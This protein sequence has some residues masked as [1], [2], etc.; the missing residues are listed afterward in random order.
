MGRRGR[1]IAQ[2]GA[3]CSR[4]LQGLLALA[5]WT[6]LGLAP[7]PV[8]AQGAARLSLPTATGHRGAR[9]EVPLRLSALAGRPLAAG[10][11]QLRFDGGV[12]AFEEV[13]TTG[14]LSAGW[15]VEYHLQ[16]AGAS[17]TLR[18]GVA[19]LQSATADG[20]LLRLA[21]RIP[22]AAPF[23]G[24]S[25]L[26]L[27]DA[28]LEQDPAGALLAVQSSHGLVRVGAPPV[29]WVNEGL[30]L[31]EG[32]SAAITPAALRV[33]DVDNPPAELVY[34][35]VWAPAAGTLS[36]PQG[37]LGQGQTFTQADI[38]QG[39]LSY[40]HDGS[41]TTADAFAFSV[42]DG[43]G[44]PLAGFFAIQV[45]PVNDP[46][47]LLPIGVLQVDEGQVLEV[48]VS[49]SDPDG[50]P[51]LT[52]QGLPPF[53]AF[54]DRGDGTGLLRLAPG[55]NAAGVYTGIV[56][57]A[58]DGTNPALVDHQ[59][60]VLT[61]VNVDRPPVANAGADIRLPYATVSAT[62]V[63]LD[64][65]GSSDPE[66]Q[67]L[68]YAWSKNGAVLAT[69]PTPRVDLALG[70]HVLTL[71]VSDGVFASAPDQVE[72]QIVDATPPVLSLLGDNP[73][74]I[75]IGTPY[76]EPG[77][78][79]RDEAAGDLSESVS[80]AGAVDVQ[81][82]GR[83]VLTYAV[84]DP[85][86]NAAAPL[87]RVVEV[88]V[89]PNSYGLIAIHSLELASRARINS[90]FV[91]VVDF[92][93]NARGDDRHAELV[94][95]TQARTAA[96]VRVSSPRVQLRN[97]A[98]IE[99]ML[100]YTEWVDPIRSVLVGQQRQ[101]GADYWPLFGQFGLPAFQV[102][103]AGSQRIDVLAGKTATLGPGA[104]NLVRVRARGT[105]ILRG[106]E[107]DVRHFEVGEQAQVRIE[108]AATVRVEGRFNM[109]QRSYF[110]PADETLDPAAIRIYVNRADQRPGDDDDE[111]AGLAANV[112]ERAHFAGNLYAPQGTIRLREE[113]RVLGSLIA[114]DI[115]IGSGVRVDGRS[116]WQT[117]GVLYAPGPLPPAAKL[118]MP[119]DLF[120]D[121]VNAGAL[122]NSPNP[123]N[124]STV[125]RYTLPADGPV[126]LVIYDALGQ[127]VRVLVGGVQQA[128]VYAVEWDGR[129]D[130]DRTV[131]SGVYLAQLLMSHSRQVH[132]LLL[133][134]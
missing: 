5:V 74:Y 122:A 98:A 129:D 125:L 109:S 12:I 29:L 68:T 10:E 71:I 82:E 102:G 4:W 33:Q 46:P 52:V 85:A 108:T 105:L 63:A 8:Q 110:G 77:A 90:G 40:A 61:V 35:L 1:I 41:E 121:E 17:Q 113:A 100:V 22:A 73:L 44:Q 91:G 95:G 133:M 128:G 30:A 80:I 69:G 54:A 76:A 45:T 94:V 9:V 79:A 81:M 96:S 13:V 20:D 19:G 112:G 47:V 115:R 14:T 101:V 26:E 83:Y 134:R 56:L 7:A 32:A 42:G 55:F 127:K 70:T 78:S 16:G 43:Q 2:L 124:P 89:T 99:G 72:V 59:V 120:S 119:L 37:S 53:A 132:K 130:Q 18:I 123:F 57:T 104:Y 64:G 31:A 114:R 117:P 36:G 103:A 111:G 118:A 97:R 23:G 67:P 11:I 86:G 49:A 34:A 21:F 106:G 3:S 15:L 62:P 75:E 58:T 38:D 50:T 60:L 25:P 28:R 92:A 87:E 84:S 66:G 93:R 116:G 126:E 131:A 51:V 107:Y 39:A 65:T 88:V 24:F 27:V 48:V 6:G